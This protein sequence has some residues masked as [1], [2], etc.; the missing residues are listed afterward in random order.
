MVHRVHEGAKEKREN[1]VLRANQHVTRGLSG[2]RKR[3]LQSGEEEHE[4]LGRKKIQPE[5]TGAPRTT[6]ILKSAFE[7]NSKA[8]RISPAD[9][10]ELT[11]ASQ[12][13]SGAFC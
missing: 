8:R 10:E 7:T 5:V 13:E 11:T 9:R 12:L 3:K 2:Q 6:K 1:R 4:T